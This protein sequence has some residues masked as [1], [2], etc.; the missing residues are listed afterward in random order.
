MSFRFRLETILKL[1]RSQE[2]AEQLALAGLRQQLAAI[3]RRLEEIQHARALSR[4]AMT[5]ELASGVIANEVHF[6]FECEKEEDARRLKLIERRIELEEE[7][8]LQARAFTESRQ[9]RETLEKLSDD[10]KAAYVLDRNRRE[11]QES[12]ELFLRG[13]RKTGM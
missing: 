5:R 9:K 13:P 6:Q 7:Y 8:Q 10:E 11:Q 3:D 2:R 12:D 1:R 4:E